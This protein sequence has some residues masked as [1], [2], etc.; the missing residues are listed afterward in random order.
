MRPVRMEWLGSLFIVEIPEGHAAH[1]IAESP[2]RTSGRTDGERC[3]LRSALRC[4]AATSCAGVR[5]AFG[6]VPNWISP[7]RTAEPRHG[8]GVST[9]KTRRRGH[10]RRSAVRACRPRLGRVSSLLSAG[11]C[12][13]GFASFEVPEDDSGPA[14]L[15]ESPAGSTSGGARLPGATRGLDSLDQRPCR[16]RA[17]VSCGRAARDRIA[18]IAAAQ[19]DQVLSARCMREPRCRCVARPAPGNGG[20]RQRRRIVVV[21]T[22]TFASPSSV[23]PLDVTVCVAFQFIVQKVG[24]NGVR[25]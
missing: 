23:P 18:G 6:L 14:L 9:V 15:N 4:N 22:F 7:L 1:C 25:S 20:K 24:D 10:R 17:E 21:A 8:A 11:S 2:S 19:L 5:P 12:S 16:L 13:A 3:C